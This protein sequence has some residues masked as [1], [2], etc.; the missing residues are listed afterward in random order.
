MYDH[1]LHR[2]KNHVCCYC[3]QV[4]STEEILKSH[5]MDRLKVNGKQMIQILKEGEY[6]NSKDYERKLKS[7]FMI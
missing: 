7:P 3:L 4:F 6:V 2:G 5:I 1:T